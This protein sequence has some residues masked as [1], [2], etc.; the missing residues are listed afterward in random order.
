MVIE[1]AKILRKYILTTDTAAREVLTN[2]PNCMVVPNDE[3]GIEKAIRTI[4]KGNIEKSNKSNDYKYS[5]YEA[6]NKIVKI[7]EKKNNEN[8]LKGTKT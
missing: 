5:N 8:L 4:I 1:E 7:I 6:I 3:D 2:Y